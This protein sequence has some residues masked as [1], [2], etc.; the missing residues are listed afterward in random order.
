MP[1]KRLI[2]ALGVAGALVAPALSVTPA[3]AVGAR[4]ATRNCVASQ[5]S[6]SHG[7]PNGAAGTIFIPIVFTNHGPACALWGVPAIQPVSGARHNPVGPLARNE[8]MG[9][10]PVR[11]VVKT[12]RSVSA[13]VG[14][15]E[16]GN[17]PSASCVAKKVSGVLVTLGSFVSRRYVALSDTV[18]TKRSSVSTRLL[19]AGVTGN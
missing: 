18:C 9:E 3:G 16:T 12:G 7:T 8:S 1:I 15:T 6:V 11:H 2:V 13:A 5:L 19:V 17:Y 4:V 10:M 14:F